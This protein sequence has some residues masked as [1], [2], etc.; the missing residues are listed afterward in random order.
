MVKIRE[1]FA[2]KCQLFGS[3]VVMKTHLTGRF[4]AALLMTDVEKIAKK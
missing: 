3:N 2:A 1:F 4:I